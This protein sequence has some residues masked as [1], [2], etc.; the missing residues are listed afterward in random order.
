MCYVSL[1]YIIKRV[2][3]ISTFLVD[4]CRV[5]QDIL[6]FLTAN[7]VIYYLLVTIATE[8]KMAILK[9]EEPKMQTI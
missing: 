1:D 6:T 2:K 5:E 3:T 4:M 7:V 8:M 9:L